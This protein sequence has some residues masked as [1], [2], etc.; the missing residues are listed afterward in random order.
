MVWNMRYPGFKAFKGMVFYSSPNVG[1]KAVPGEYT[2]RLNYNGEVVEQALQIVKDPRLSNT[3]EDYKAQFDF[4][5]SVRDEVSRANNAIIEIR[6]VQKDLDY[7]K[8]KA[9]NNSDLLAYISSFE[10][11]LSR[12]ENNIHMTKNQSRQDPLN[13]GIRIN[14]RIAFLLAD[15]QRG[16][17]P[18][19][20]QAQAFFKEISAELQTE[21]TALDKLMSESV[22]KLNDMVSAAQIEMIS[23]KNP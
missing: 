6:R 15:S 8:Q 2:I 3:D 17:Y 9:Q 23:S 4:L 7:L 22:A 11:D 12:I 20:D 18:P 13:Y 16:D 5:I 10:K 1:P 21:L 19:T 14:N